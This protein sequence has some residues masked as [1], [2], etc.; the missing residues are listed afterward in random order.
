MNTVLLKVASGD[1]FLESQYMDIYKLLRAAWLGLTS[2]Q[3]HHS[4]AGCRNTTSIDSECNLG[5][6][7]PRVRT[8]RSR[9]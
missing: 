4:V 6:L 5:L 8:S 3:S 9:T 7:E 2:S 1:I